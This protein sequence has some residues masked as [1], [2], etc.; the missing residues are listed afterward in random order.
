MWTVNSDKLTSVHPGLTY[1]LPAIGDLSQHLWVGIIPY[2][3]VC[4]CVSLRWYFFPHR[5][6]SCLLSTSFSPR[7]V[8]LSLN[9]YYTTVCISVC[10]WVWWEKDEPGVAGCKDAAIFPQADEMRPLYTPMSRWWAPDA[11]RQPPGKSRY[12]SPINTGLWV[13]TARQLLPPLVKLVKQKNK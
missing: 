12:R 3:C 6:L 13:H 2:V 9:V 11:R 10:I 1:L 4:V 8:Y 5:F 7:G